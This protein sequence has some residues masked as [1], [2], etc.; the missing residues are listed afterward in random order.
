MPRA[1]VN[2]GERLTIK[3][4]QLIA[5]K[6]FN[7]KLGWSETRDIVNRLPGIARPLFTLSL[8]LLDEAGLRNGSLVG[9]TGFCRQQQFVWDIGY[10]KINEQARRHYLEILVTN[11]PPF[12]DGYL[13]PAG[14]SRSRSSH[15]IPLAELKTPDWLGK[16]AEIIEEKFNGGKKLTIIGLDREPAAQGAKQGNEIGNSP[17]G[18]DEGDYAYFIDIRPAKLLPSRGQSCRTGR[19][20]TLAIAKKG[21]RAKI[22]TVEANQVEE[23]QGEFLFLSRFSIRTGGGIY[24]SLDSLGIDKSLQGK[25][26]TSAFYPAFVRY[27]SREFGGCLVT[28]AIAHPAFLHLFKKSFLKARPIYPY[29]AARIPAWGRPVHYLGEIPAKQSALG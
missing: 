15:Q 8:R 16:L 29:E 1:I 24:I 25:K 14:P 23:S 28:S 21:R 26:L 20:I 10:L 6:V 19:T 5:F 2:L 22:A 7:E 13:G 11:F 17:A 27:L 12:S 3:E 9:L 18:S 4:A